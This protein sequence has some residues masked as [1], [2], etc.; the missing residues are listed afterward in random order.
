MNY[1]KCKNELIIDDKIYF[2]NINYNYDY[3]II[4]EDNILQLIYVVFD[5]NGEKLYCDKEYFNNNFK[6]I[7]LK[8]QLC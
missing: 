8:E 6:I 1:C 3:I 2:T 5:I 4:N 7:K